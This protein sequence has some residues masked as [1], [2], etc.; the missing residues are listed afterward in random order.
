M[1]AAGHHCSRG[2]S[3]WFPTRMDLARVLSTVTNT[4]YLL[5]HLIPTTQDTETWRGLV[6]NMRTHN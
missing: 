4:F 5:C 2:T 1:L 6:T 3:K